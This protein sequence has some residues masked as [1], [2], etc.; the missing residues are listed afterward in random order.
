[1]RCFKD[2][3]EFFRMIFDEFLPKC[4]GFLIRPEDIR[5]EGFVGCE[6]FCGKI[7]EI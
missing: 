7:N 1:V 6:L 3:R 4:N 5:L 2:F